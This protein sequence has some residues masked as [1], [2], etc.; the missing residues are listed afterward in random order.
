LD[1]LFIPDICFSSFQDSSLQPK[2]ACIVLLMILNQFSV[3]F[4]FP[5]HFVSF[6]I[7]FEINLSVFTITTIIGIAKR[8]ILRVFC[9]TDTKRP[10][11]KK[12]LAKLLLK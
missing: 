10:L 11:S 5:F 2:I 8:R 7:S 1:Y 9:M 3:A 6:L 4:E 12:V